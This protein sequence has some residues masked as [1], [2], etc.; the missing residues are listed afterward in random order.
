MVGQTLTSPACA[1]QNGWVPYHREVD[2]LINHPVFGVHWN[3]ASIYVE[4]IVEGRRYL[5]KCSLPD[6]FG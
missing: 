5:F 1:R 2:N 4:F 3:S 6:N